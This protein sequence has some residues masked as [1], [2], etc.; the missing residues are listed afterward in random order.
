MLEA[1]FWK[2]EDVADDMVDNEGYGG[3]A[4]LALVRSMM[5]NE[6]WV[7]EAISSAGPSDV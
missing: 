7:V 1:E 6:G 3:R 5:V 4:P 2:A